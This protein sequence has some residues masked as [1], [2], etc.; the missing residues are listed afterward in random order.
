MS[1]EPKLLPILPEG[2]TRGA[3]YA[4]AVQ[5]PATGLVLVAGQFGQDPRTGAFAKDFAAQW[6]QA[7]SNV[8]E[9]AKTVGRGPDSI[10]LIRI[11]VRS[12]EEYRAARNGVG[13]VQREVLGKWFP[14]TTMVEIGGL[15]EAEARLEIEAVIRA[16][17]AR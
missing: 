5:D 11:F 4:H 2:W 7:L 15:V 6:K 13:A 9:V 3:G 14:A 12:L 16:P 8:V 17:A 1:G 10:M